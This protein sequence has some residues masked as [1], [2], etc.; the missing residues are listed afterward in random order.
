MI[1]GLTGGIASGKSEAAAELARL[2]AMVIDADVVAREMVMPGAPAYARLVMEFGDEILDGDGRIDRPLLARVIFAD[3]RKRLLLN[4]ITHPAIFTEMARQINDYS[5]RL[6]R[7]DVPAVVV[8]AA[9]IVDVGV[10]GVFDVLVVVT[11]DEPERFGRLVQ[12]RG[13]D[14]GEAKERIRSQVPDR[15]RVSMADIVIE[16]NGTIQDLRLRVA[17]VWEDISR[18]ARLH[19]S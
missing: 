5:A 17:R 4:S 12:H 15:K 14:E 8:D 19:H 9:L 2:G 3:E 18:T 1:I 7:S 16:N 13:M 11:S 6:T 10:T